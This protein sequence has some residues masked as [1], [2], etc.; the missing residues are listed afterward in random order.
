[1]G[2]VKAGFVYNADVGVNVMWKHRPRRP[3][4]LQ[5]TRCRNHMPHWYSRIPRSAHKQH[6]SVQS[7]L[8]CHLKTCWPDTTSVWFVTTKTCLSVR[9]KRRALTH[10]PYNNTMEQEYVDF[11]TATLTW[12]TIRWGHQHRP[13]RASFWQQMSDFHH[14]TCWRGASEWRAGWTSLRVTSRS[15]R[16]GCPDLIQVLRDLKWIFWAHYDLLEW[17]TQSFLK[18]QLNNNTNSSK[19]WRLDI[20]CQVLSSSF[21]NPFECRKPKTGCQTS[22][23]SFETWKW[24]MKETRRHPSLERLENDLKQTSDLIQV[25]RDLKWLIQVFWDLKWLIQVLRTWKWL[26]TKIRPHPSLERLETH[27]SLENLKMT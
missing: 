8:R 6:T 22:S 3:L 1:M 25:L 19:S 11:C 23:K 12:M 18:W 16:S 20:L 21:L 5:W 10:T 24:L 17:T 4:T 7:A 2:L 13:S 26:K 9:W 14:K 15:H 27:P